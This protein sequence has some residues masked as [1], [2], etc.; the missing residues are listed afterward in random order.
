MELLRE[1]MTMEHFCKSHIDY[2]SPAGAP[3]VANMIFPGYQNY[4]TIVE[5]R[6][7]ELGTWPPSSFE[8]YWSIYILSRLLHERNTAED[9]KLLRLLP[10]Y[11]HS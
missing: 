3:Q 8:P 7:N 9:A 11:P 5:R 2:N 10:H 6:R 1:D 4:E